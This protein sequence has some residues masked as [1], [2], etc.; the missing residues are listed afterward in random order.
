MI[1]LVR[2]N[3]LPNLVNMLF[4]LVSLFHW[5]NIKFH[6]WFTYMGFSLKWTIESFFIVEVRQNAHIVSN[7]LDLFIC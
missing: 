3:L 6:I 7:K 4:I 5:N 2:T 1:T